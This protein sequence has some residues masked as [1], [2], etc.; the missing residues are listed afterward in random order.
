MSRDDGQ[1]N[2][3][4]GAQSRGGIKAGADLLCSFAPIVA[5]TD[6]DQCDD[7]ADEEQANH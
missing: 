7:G 1:G 5:E 3:C 2:R 4:S 6:D